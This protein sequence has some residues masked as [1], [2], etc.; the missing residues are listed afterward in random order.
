MSTSLSHLKST[1]LCKISPMAKHSLNTKPVNFM[2]TN[3]RE[4][5]VYKTGWHEDTLLGRD[6]LLLVTSCRRLSDTLP[7]TQALNCRVDS[8]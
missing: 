3:Y 8:V 1:S 2:K 5:S 7:D 6:D 4:Y